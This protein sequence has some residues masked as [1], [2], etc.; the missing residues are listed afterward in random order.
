MVIIRVLHL[1]QIIVKIMVEYNKIPIVRVI[2]M[3]LHPLE[4]IDVIKFVDKLLYIL[5]EIHISLEL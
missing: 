2:G 5:L 1:I 4:L 3:I